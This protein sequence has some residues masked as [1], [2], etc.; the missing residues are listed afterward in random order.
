[1]TRFSRYKQ[2]S[3]F[4][5]AVLALVA[6]IAAGCVKKVT[7]P[8]A[9][10]GDVAADGG[11][12]AAD[13]LFE[14]AD[15]TGA[16]S[17]AFTDSR[18]CRKYRAVKIGR[19]IWMA[20]NLNYETDNSWCL[21][22]DKSNCV[23]FGRLYDW[24]AAQAACPAGWHLS[25]AAEW[26]S[27]MLAAGGKREADD[28]NKDGWNHWTVADR[29]LKAKSDWKRYDNA[30]AGESGP[31]TDDYGFS[32]LPGG[33]R[34]RRGEFDEPGKSAIWWT[35]KESD[36]SGA[37]RM[38]MG[39]NFSYIGPI[40]KDEGHSVRCVSDD[41]IIVKAGER[42]TFS[43]TLKTGDG[44]ALSASPRKDSYAIGEKVTITAAPDDGYAFAGWTGGRTADSAS[45]VTVITVIS[46]TTVAANF[47]RIDY[48]SFTDERNGKTY[49]T[50]K[51]GRRTWMA[52]NLNYESEDGGSSCRNGDAGNC[53]KYGRLYDW[54]TAQEVCPAGWQL[55]SFN[56]WDALAVYAGGDNAAGR[57]LKAASGWAGNGGYRGKGTDDYGFSA[58]PG[59]G[60]PDRYENDNIFGAWW[61]A[62]TMY[63]GA[64]NARLTLHQ[65]NLR[66]L[67]TDMSDMYSVRCI[68]DEGGTIILNAEE[69][70]TVSSVPRKTSFKAGETATITA[71]PKSGYVFSRWTGGKV[72]DP[73]AAVTT[74]AV[75]SNMSV[76]A[77]FRAAP[78]ASGT[79][80]DK[81]DGQ[82]Y[83]TAQIGNQVWTA[84]D[85][86]YKTGKS[87]CYNDSDSYCE[88][89]GRLY[90]WETAITVCP[91]GWHLPSR[92]EWDALVKAV[93]GKA[94]SNDDEDDYKSK[95]AC[96]AL[97]AKSGWRTD[98]G[99]AGNGTDDYGFAALPVGKR[100]AVCYSSGS[101]SDNGC[102]HDAGGNGDWWSAT[103][104]GDS[105]YIWGINN[106]FGELG[107]F[108][109]NKDWGVA[110][111]C[112]MDGG[113]KSAQKAKRA[114]GKDGKPEIEM[115][116]VKGGTFKLGCF[117]D[118]RNDCHQKDSAHNV[119]LNDFHIGKY[120]VTQKQWKQV[121]GDNPS[122]GVLGDDYPVNNI[123]WYDIQ[124]FIERLNA[125]TG[126]KYRLPTEAEWEYA[127]RGGAGS[128]GYKYSG[129]D[130][131]DDVAWHK[132]N[133]GGEAHPV[134]LKAPNEL[135]LY[136]MTGNVW[137]FT[138][139]WHGDYGA[140]DRVNPTG[141]REG[142]VRV[143]RGGYWGA[144]AYGVYSRGCLPPGTSTFAMGFRLILLP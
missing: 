86:N 113:N 112:V 26:D 38:D 9:G 107:G 90:D 128:K 10:T 46:D 47:R 88:K 94:M 142:T 99:M 136:D 141:P 95:R 143:G 61:T 35:S 24:D 54:N 8:T 120:E 31:G 124:E 55:P 130:N 135:G 84:R 16:S 75:R 144:E 103:A 101:K 39:H 37:Y 140:D 104:A 41:G 105:A 56:D 139:D 96:K 82:K 23:K 121:M 80:A 3:L 118:N 115:A 44:G 93:S 65:D 34:Y 33:Q 15:S 69:G 114:A 12:G 30:K 85:M 102:Y 1:M 127:A 66:G 27:L 138:G 73:T 98:D 83:K 129:S 4:T 22:D 57:K 133:S 100:Q 71:T 5:A 7:A 59:G 45:L 2:A 110:V 17:L 13:I 50:V 28:E 125:A 77:L 116:F 91:A 123:N 62:T 132:E 134:G 29:K 70:G 49:R 60:E 11:C 67:A 58:L 76:T 117:D 108:Y 43:L 89:Y 126:K 18:D 21:G 68:M 78:G 52:E 25:T 14:S 119:T 36:G 20:Q 40:F 48:G 87:W 32:A 42:G 81:R 106:Y 19:D 137:E 72:A 111:R 92:A 6:V 97:K 122:G 63:G 79:L 131:P 53:E 51:I 74:V 109:I 64:V